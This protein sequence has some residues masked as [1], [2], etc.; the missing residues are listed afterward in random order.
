MHVDSNYDKSNI[1]LLNH[2]NKI[3]TIKQAFSNQKY[4]KEIQAVKRYIINNPIMETEFVSPIIQEFNIKVYIDIENDMPHSVLQ[5]LELSNEPYA[6]LLPIL[7]K[8]PGLQRFYHNL[9][10]PLSETL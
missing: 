7:Q 6:K 2:N 5:Y 8:V 10:L 4:S 1:E 9:F 3:H